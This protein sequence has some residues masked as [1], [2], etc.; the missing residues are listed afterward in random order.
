MQ[1]SMV[2]IV[3]HFILAVNDREWLYTDNLI[4]KQFQNQ[5]PLHNIEVL[6]AL[7]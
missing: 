1:G 4:M 5:P 6:V 3:V 7:E 2:Y